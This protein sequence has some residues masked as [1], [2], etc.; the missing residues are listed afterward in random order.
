MLLNWFVVIHV[1][2]AVLCPVS[3]EVVRPEEVQVHGSRPPPP[4]P[5][6]SWRRLPVGVALLWTPQLLLLSL[7]F[8]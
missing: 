4:P 3:G 7:L 8:L 6:P 5:L 2:P 1:S